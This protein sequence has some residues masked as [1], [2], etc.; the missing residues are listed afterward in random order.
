M[1]FHFI[2]F[3]RPEKGRSGFLVWRYLLRRDDPSLA[4]WEQGATKYPCIMPDMMKEE[5]ALDQ[6]GNP[7]K[8]IKLE[9]YHPD[10]VMV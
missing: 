4:P 3:F 8:K 6:D 9:K 7:A 10:E 1:I 2:I 5:E